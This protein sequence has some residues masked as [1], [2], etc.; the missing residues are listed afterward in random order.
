MSLVRMICVVMS[1]GGG[2]WPFA[3]HSAWASSAKVL[4]DTAAELQLGAQ[5]LQIHPF[6]TALPA[7]A[8]LPAIQQTYG[9][10]CG[11]FE[12]YLQ[13]GRTQYFLAPGQS[14]CVV[15]VHSQ[16]SGSSGTLSLSVSGAKQA[17]LPELW[18]ALSWQV[19]WQYCDSA[20]STES[21]G[22]LEPPQASCLLLLKASQTQLQSQHVF[23]QH[24]Q[25]LH[26]QA[27][28]EAQAMEWQGP[29]RQLLSVHWQADHQ[30]VIVLCQRCD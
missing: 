3:M 7:S 22:S 24:L 10:V 25:S 18:Q 5:H 20:L 15:Q 8:V 12:L 2:A 30:H 14:E 21:L 26:W 27:R 23:A 13:A 29:A 4:W 19:L 9:V 1:L 6:S 11:D 16:P 17:V 28:N